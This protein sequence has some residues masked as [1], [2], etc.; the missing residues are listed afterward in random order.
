MFLYLDY[1][2][3]FFPTFHLQS[4]LY[5]G[6]VSLK[7]VLVVYLFFVLVIYYL[8]EGLCSVYYCQ[9]VVDYGLLR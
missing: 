9:I 1:D 7:S 5:Y 8:P 4:A 6:P 2:I 3:P